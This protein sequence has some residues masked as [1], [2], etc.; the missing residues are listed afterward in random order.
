MP[1]NVVDCVNISCIGIPSPDYKHV[2]AEYGSLQYQQD[3][4]YECDRGK[5]GNRDNR[6]FDEM[7]A[8]FFT[9]TGS[10]I[11]TIQCNHD[12]NYSEPTDQCVPVY[13]GPPPT[14]PNTILVDN[15]LN[16]KFVQILTYKCQPGRW[17][18]EGTIKVTIS[19]TILFKSPNIHPHRVDKNNWFVVQMVGNRPNSN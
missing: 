14:I 10:N 5:Y 1:E 12:G 4:I 13:C 9:S 18:S 11:F 19:S 3:W 2:I 8:G 7:F 6:W 17:F 15:Q 16:S